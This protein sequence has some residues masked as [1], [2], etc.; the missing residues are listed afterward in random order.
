LKDLK[1]RPKEIDDFL[2]MYSRLVMAGTI[3][4]FTVV[5]AIFCLSFLYEKDG[6]VISKV[7]SKPQKQRVNKA[8]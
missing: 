5:L 6:Q 7:I 3:L 1:D 8:N 2:K 4:I